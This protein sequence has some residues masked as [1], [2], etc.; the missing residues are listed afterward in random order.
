MEHRRDRTSRPDSRAYILK[1]A[2]EVFLSE[3]FARASVDRVAAVARMSKQSIYELFPSKT[4]L[5]QAAVL[6]AL[7]SARDDMAV[8]DDKGDPA[9]TFRHFA[10]RIFDGFA[11]PVNFGLFRANILAASHFPA[12]AGDLHERRLAASRPLADYI[13]KL[14]A[15]G[16]TDRCDPSATAIRFGGLVV[17]GSRYFLGSPLPGPA[18]RKAIIRRALD[19]FLNGYRARGEAD[20]DL[21]AFAPIDPP[22]L[23]G[24]AA[25]RLSSEKLTALVDAAESDFLEFGYHRASVDRIAASVRASKATVYRQFGS[26]ESLFRYVIQREIFETSRAAIE[27]RIPASGP[28]VALTALARQA[29]D[30]HLAPRNIHMHRLL[31]QEVDLVPD[32]ARRFH[33]VRV[34][35]LADAL[36]TVL[37]AHSQLPPV[38]ADA[39]AFYTM[40]TFAVRFLTTSTLPTPP[41]RDLLSQEC[42]RLFLHGL[43]AR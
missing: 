12:L 29:L 38:D 6:D 15:Q 3:G 30:L 19:L 23:E 9:S 21:P 4:E 14:V 10:E 40:A 16:L 33:E 17:E 8:I 24:T 2:A 34:Q 39:R 36:R 32:L 5:F 22:V 28:E 1:A 11:D 25:L 31:I 27:P 13:E 41:Q 26:K 37:A 42:A 20:G 18:E 35:R 43:K 7:D